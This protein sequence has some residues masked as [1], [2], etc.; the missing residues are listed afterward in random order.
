MRTV[1]SDVDPPDPTSTATRHAPM[2]ASGCPTAVAFGSLRTPVSR[3]VDPDLDAAT[4][5]DTGK[6]PPGKFRDQRAVR[7][8]DASATCHQDSSVAAAAG[9]RH[10]VGNDSRHGPPSPAK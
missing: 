6:V 9:D 4:P 7:K 10:N 3:A 8:G 2:V 1:T 5:L